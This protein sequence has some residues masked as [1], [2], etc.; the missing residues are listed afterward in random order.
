M[1]DKYGRKI[2]FDV[3]FEID[4]GNI[5]VSASPYNKPIVLAPKKD[6]SW[7][8]CIDNYYALNKIIVK[9]Q[10]SLPHIDDLLDQL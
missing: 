7:C 6:C 10:Y 2:R 3:G 5:R 9:I 4:Q 8:L 1:V